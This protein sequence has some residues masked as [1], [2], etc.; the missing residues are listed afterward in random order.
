MVR[1]ID[2]VWAVD[3]IDMQH[4]AKDNDNYRFILAVIDVFS[5]F[6]W[7][8]ALK[9][10]SG[11]EVASALNDIITSSGRK[12]THVWSDKGTEF[13]NKHVKK[14]VELISTENEEKS[15]VVERWNRTMK[16]RMFKYF[17]ANNTLRY[18]D[19]LDDMVTQYNNTKHSSIKM[20]PVQASN[21]ENLYRT[22][23]N[24]YGDIVHDNSPR[25]KP[26][27]KVGDKIRITVKKDV[28]R[29]GYLPRWTEELFTVSA[30]QYTDPITYK[31]KD[32]NGEEIKGTFYEQEMQK[33]TQETFRIEKVLK[34]KGN[35]LLVKWMGY[36]D[37]FNSWIDKKDVQSIGNI[38]HLS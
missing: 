2:A 38:H 13:Y 34:T 15:C 21:P 18:V 30:I 8:R 26:K 37:D 27:F 9:S 6:G 24:L 5:K 32:L 35:K 23:M 29:K 17:T 36:S 11:T 7:M 3:L 33:S 28:F 20:T 31:I 16:D 1:G 22:Y 10:K 14:L 12:P 25:P 4:Y 19:V